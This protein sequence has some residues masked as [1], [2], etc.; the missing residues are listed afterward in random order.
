MECRVEDISTAKIVII[1]TRNQSPHWF[2]FLSNRPTVKTIT[3]PTQPHHQLMLI[4]KQML[5][6][7]ILLYRLLQGLWHAV[8]SILGNLWLI[9]FI[10]TKLPAMCEDIHIYYQAALPGILYGSILHVGPLLLYLI[11]INDIPDFTAS[12]THIMLLFADNTKCLNLLEICLT[13]TDCKR[14]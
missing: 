12:S 13:H 6:Y 11:F 14:I 7:Y 3:N 4:I 1:A 2:G 5:Q 8:Y 10:L 9:H